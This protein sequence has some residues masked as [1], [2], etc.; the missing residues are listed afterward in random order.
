ML[1]C[2]NKD[3]ANAVIIIIIII[4]NNNSSI[5]INSSNIMM[6]KVFAGHLAVQLE[7]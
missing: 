2:H 3:I 5:I 6:I 1:F 4:I 7:G